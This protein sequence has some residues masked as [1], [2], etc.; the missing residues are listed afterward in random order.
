VTADKLREIGEELRLVL[1]GRGGLVD[2]LVP[3]A[4]FLVCNATLG[5]RMAIWLALGAA[6]GFAGWRLLKRQSP[7]YALGG[8]GAVVVAGLLAWA[9]GRAEGF[10]LPGMVSGALAVIGCLVSVLFRRPLVAW[11]SYVTRRWPLPWY[12][13]ARVRPA[14]TEVTLLWAVVFALRLALQWLLY[15]QQLSSALGLAQLLT[16]WPVTI[17][18]LVLSYLYG[19]WRLRNLNGPSVEEFRVGAS[20]PWTGQRRGF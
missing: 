8:L 3:P 10:F 7:H 4:L 18:L 15:R 14:Y 12:W 5:L 16:G 9:M 6:L 2:A 19:T 20:P 13:H 1:R 17:V 11:T